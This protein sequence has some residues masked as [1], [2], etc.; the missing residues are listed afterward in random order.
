VKNVSGGFSIRKDW[1]GRSNN[2]ENFTNVCVFGLNFSELSARSAGSSKADFSVEPRIKET[3]G[4]LD[5]LTYSSV[6]A[7]VS[8]INGY[9]SRGNENR[10]SRGVD[11][12]G[13]SMQNCVEVCP[14]SEFRLGGNMSS[15]VGSVAGIFSKLF[16]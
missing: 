3:N 6:D 1:S 12:E 4:K 7:R 14:N 8:E 9:K 11:R 15:V 5:G 13:V 2:C 10:I 16:I